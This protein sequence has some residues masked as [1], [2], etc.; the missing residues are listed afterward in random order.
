MGASLAHFQ[1]ENLQKNYVQ[2]MSFWQK[3]QGVN[4]INDSPGHQA[5]QLYFASSNEMKT[6]C[7]LD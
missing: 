6:A 7:R 1:P 2:K 3:A 5:R 4:G